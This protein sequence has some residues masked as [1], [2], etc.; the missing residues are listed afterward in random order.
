VEIKMDNIERQ[1]IQKN[2]DARA[3][4][5][6]IDDATNERNINW[7]MTNYPPFLNAFHWNLSELTNQGALVCSSQRILFFLITGVGFWNFLQTYVAL[8]MLLLL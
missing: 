2:L 3:P 7:H 5:E 8:S 4:R 6:S 1:T